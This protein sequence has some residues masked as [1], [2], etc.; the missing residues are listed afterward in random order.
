MEPGAGEEVVKIGMGL[1]ATMGKHGGLYDEE[2]VAISP[3][4]GTTKRRKENIIRIKQTK[5]KMT[6][7][8]CPGGG[9]PTC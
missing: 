6:R 7:D 3:T 9:S 1:T 8:L 5:K 2:R 4:A